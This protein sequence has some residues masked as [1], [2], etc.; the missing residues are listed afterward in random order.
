MASILLRLGLDFLFTSLGFVVMHC[1]IM[2]IR[3]HVFHFAVFDFISSRLPVCL[4]CFLLLAVCL[5]TVGESSTAERGELRDCRSANLQSPFLI[6][7]LRA[8]L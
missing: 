3:L 5:V 6:S 7:A 2:L 4:L 1:V 8:C